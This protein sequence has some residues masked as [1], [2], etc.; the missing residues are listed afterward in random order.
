[1]RR[2]SHSTSALT[3]LL[4][5]VLAVP[6]SASA[7]RTRR[8]RPAAQDS[9]RNDSG[10][11]ILNVG[12]YGRWKR[13]NSA[14]LSPDGRWMTYAYAPNDGDDTLFVKQLGTDK[15]YTIPR[16]AAPSFSDD[17]HWV[18]YYVSP[19]KRTGRGRGGRSETPPAPEGRGGR[20]G[21]A[22]PRTF[23]LLDL[24]TGDKWA[25]PN[26]QAFNFAK[27]SKS[28]AVHLARASRTDTTH[29]GSDLLLRDLAT[30]NTRNVGN[31]S[32][33]DF[34]DAGNLLAYTVDASDRLGNGD[35]PGRSGQRRHARSRCH[36]PGLRRHGLE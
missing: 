4:A 21:N 25:A 36:A 22:G 32:Q 30:G 9:A 3:L 34:D 14:D 1:M 12:D 11:R 20:G 8:A 17:S 5:L 28:L 24:S 2:T 23:E 13:I 7:Q 33:Y 6:T 29:K 35:L 19:P 18:G 15:L 10:P 27:G 26:A 31:V 16:G